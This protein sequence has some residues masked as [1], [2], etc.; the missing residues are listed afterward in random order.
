MTR[1]FLI[2]ADDLSGAADC[3]MA[4]VRAGLQARVCLDAS[5]AQSPIEALAIDLDTRHRSVD[6]AR[7]ATL[8]LSGS[9]GPGVLYRK[10]DSTLRGHIG[11]EVAA[12]LRIAGPAAFA[13]VCPAYPAMGRTMIDGQVWVGG[14]SLGQTEIWRHEG[15]GAPDLDAILRGA[16]LI[17]AHLGLALV[18]GGRLA[19]AL[20]WAVAGGA[21]ALIC[22]AATEDDMSAIAAAGLTM[23]GVV[24][25]GSGGL[26]IPLAAAVTPRPAARR[27]APVRGRGPLLVV[28]GSASSVSRRQLEALGHDPGAGL[29]RVPPQVL[30]DGPDAPGWRP[31]SRSLVAAIGKPGRDV[32][33][34]AIDPDAS[35]DAVN[36][37]RLA[38]ALGRLIGPQLAR[39]GGLVATGGETAR[40]VL[41][42][43]GV[44][45]LCV[46]REVEPGIPLSSLEGRH[47]PVVTKAG[48]FGDLMSL[49]RCVEALRALPLAST[50]VSGASVQP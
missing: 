40:H 20:A 42:A 43:G 36:G 35:F 7:E 3:A 32:V 39:F 45:G 21:R 12:T 1:K 13:I 33:I 6:D 18:R 16:G 37:P 25:A 17:T 2:L 27:P 48:A 5:K 24:W 46:E 47:L 15:Q 4:C 11:V 38:T 26:A 34:A 10:I 23:N 44:H 22:D 9:L 50:G 30:L 49:V 19:A 28:V 8:S 29:I 41:E 31:I 14:A